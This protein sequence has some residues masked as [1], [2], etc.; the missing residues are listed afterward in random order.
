MPSAK[1]SPQACVVAASRSRPHAPTQYR[2]RARPPRPAPGARTRIPTARRYS[3]WLGGPQTRPPRSGQVRCIGPRRPSARSSRRSLGLRL[4]RSFPISVRR[5]PASLPCSARSLI[6]VKGGNTVPVAAATPSASAI[7]AAT[8]SRSPVH[9]VDKAKEARC[10]GSCASTPASRTSL[11]CLAEIARMPSSSHTAVLAPIAAHPQ[12]RASSTGIS[13]SA[14][15]ARCNVGVA[16]ACPS[17]VSC[18]MPSSSSSRARL[19]RDGG[20]SART[21]RQISRMTSPCPAM[22]AA[23]QAVR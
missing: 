16:A 8:P 20:G 14:S 5:P 11:T 18:A 22:P 23:P 9:E 1:S 6:K 7:S 4:A 15:A 12:R 19:G 10:R 21:A 3:R 13:R 17:V 2:P